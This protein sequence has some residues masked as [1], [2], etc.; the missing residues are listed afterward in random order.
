MRRAVPL[1]SQ[2]PNCINNRLHYK[3][4]ADYERFKKV[5]FQGYLD[6]IKSYTGARIEQLKNS[7]NVAD[8]TLYNDALSKLQ[9]AE[10]NVNAFL[11]CLNK[12]IIQRNDYAAKLY[13]LQQEI[14]ALR[15]EAN[16]KK[17]IVLE[18]KERST[19][20]DK[21]Y[22]HTTYYESWFPLGRPMQ[23]E[24]VPVLLAISIFMSIFSLGIFLRFAGKELRF[25]SV[26][27]STNA[28]LKN[29]NIRK[30]P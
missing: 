3:S 4:I 26:G 27:S 22:T 25:D 14:E 16:E 21:P 15:K 8:T 23:K 28:F 12:D 17:G 2:D 18:A 10:N 7:N 1:P 9:L 24:S 19:Q 13:D 5:E 6:T 29:M 30:Y 20:L 11:Q